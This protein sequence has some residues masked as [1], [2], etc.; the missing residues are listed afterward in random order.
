MHFLKFFIREKS[1]QNEKVRF[2]K[3]NDLK[4]S[5]IQLLSFFIFICVTNDSIRSDLKMFKINYKIKE[6][7]NK[8]KNHTECMKKNRLPRK[9][10][11]YKTRGYRSRIRS[12]LQ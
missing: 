8:L 1:T 2:I 10:L 9:L 12:V 3:E 5:Q 6:F 11:I 7:L 4:V